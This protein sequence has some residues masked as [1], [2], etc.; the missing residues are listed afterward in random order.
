MIKHKKDDHRVGKTDH[1]INDKIIAK[2]LRVISEDGEN[3]GVISKEEALARA[4]GAGL[5]LVKIGEHDSIVIAKIMDF[6]KSLYEKKK[7]STEAKKHQKIIQVK[8]IK[9]RPNIGDQDFNTKFKH[10]VEFLKDGKKVKFTL[11]FRGRELLM[12]EDIGKRFFDRITKELEKESFGSS[13][14]EEKEQKGRPFWFKI[15][16]VK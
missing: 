5:D 3:L 12:M 2:Q 6:G 7:R 13:L 11:Q 15:Y 4:A 9:M 10:A 14:V 1:Y 8:E 16:F